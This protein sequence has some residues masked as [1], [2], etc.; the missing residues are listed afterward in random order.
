MHVHFPKFHYLDL[1]HAKLNVEDLS[2]LS[3]LIQLRPDKGLKSLVVGSTAMSLTAKEKM[4][5][6]K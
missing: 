3:A 6:S 1:L 5:D 2:A 4:V